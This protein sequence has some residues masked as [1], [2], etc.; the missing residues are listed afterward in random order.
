MARNIPNFAHAVFAIDLL[1]G[2]R[3]E[4]AGTLWN[5][6]AINNGIVG[7][8][9]EDG[10]IEL[11]MGGMHNGFERALLFSVNINKLNGQTPAPDRYIFKGIPAADIGEFILLPH[12][13][14]G[15]HFWRSNAVPS[16]HLV[17]VQHSKE[18]ELATIEGSDNPILF[19]YRFDKN[20]NFKWVDCADNAQ[21]LRDTLVVK[22]VL[23]PP[24]TNTNEYF[25]ILR[26]QIQYW[27]EGRFI[28]IDSRKL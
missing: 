1:T 2:K 6:G 23:D 28:N 13:D 22:G 19:Y 7:D 15:K 5:A 4:D 16:Q 24:F 14:Y 25:E 21:Q 9:N 11:V 20:L 17:F 10:T 27:D 12:T 18:F 3:F 8:F 26:K